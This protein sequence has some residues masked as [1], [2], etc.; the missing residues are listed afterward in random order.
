[1]AINNTY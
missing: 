1:M